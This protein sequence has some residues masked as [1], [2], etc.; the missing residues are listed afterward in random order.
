MFGTIKIILMILT[1]SLPLFKEIIPL[2]VSPKYRSLALIAANM[3]AQTAEQFSGLSDTE[4]REK[5]FNKIKNTVQARRLDGISDSDINLALELAVKKVKEDKGK[6]A[7]AQ[8]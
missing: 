4:M 3:V 8:K 5:A 2:L 1:N 6:E 7:E